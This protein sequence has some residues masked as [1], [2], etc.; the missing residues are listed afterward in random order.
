MSVGLSSHG[1]L[2]LIPE[3]TYLVRFGHHSFRIKM[4]RSNSVHLS[5]LSWLP[6]EL[7][8]PMRRDWWRRRDIFI[9]LNRQRK[10]WEWQKSREKS[11]QLIFALNLGSR[12]GWNGISWYKWFWKLEI[13][14]AFEILL[15]LR[16]DLA[17][18]DLA[19]VR[20]SCKSFFASG[21]DIKRYT[22]T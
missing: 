22:I 3:L 1:R 8:L 18:P 21:I 5:F 10:R 12:G 9:N 15:S 13:N 14:F 6:R 4:C 7:F 19:I 16:Q 2:L 17:R 20:P 11:F